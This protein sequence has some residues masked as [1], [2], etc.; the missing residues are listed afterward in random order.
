MSEYILEMNH[1]TKKFPGVVALDDVSLKVKKGEIHAL[2]GE[3]GA[4]KSTLIKVLSGVYPS[5]SYEGEIIVK[6]Q[7]QNFQNIKDSE[8]IG[9]A[10][11]YQ[12]LTLIKLLSI[13]E[14][15]FL[16]NEF[17]S[18]GVIDWDRTFVEAQKLLKEVKLDDDP[19]TKVIELGIGKQ[20]LVEIAKALSKNVELLIL[21]EPTSALNE[22]DSKNLL[23]IIK[24]LKSKGVTC[25]YISH[26][27]EEVME[28]A[29]TVT[30]LRDG[31]TIC[32]RDMHDD[33]E[34][35]TEDEMIAN[36]VGRKLT[37]RFPRK[38]HKPGDVVMEINNWTV[39]NP[40]IHEK[41]VIDHVNL[42]A[43][44]G[45]I[46][47][48][49][50]LIGAG[51]TEFAMSLIGAYG[52]NVSGEIKIEGKPVSI[53]NPRDAI[54][55]GIGYLSEDRKAKGLVLIMDIMK[56]TSL[57]SLEKI[58]NGGVIDNNEEIKRANQF[59]E[60]LSIKTPS[61]EQKVENLSGGN[62]QKVAIAKWLMT[63]PKILILDEPTRGIDVGAKYEIYN[64]MNDLVERG[65]CVIMISSELPEI[66]GM[67]DRIIVMNRGKITG[68]LSYKEA[69]QEKVMY[70]ATG[71]K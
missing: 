28:I 7:K 19:E 60:R 47:G 37:Q 21:D 39:Y 20:Q 57:A 53:K 4:G 1:I 67:S 18:N 62:Q 59:V 50:G 23:S 2:V 44:K 24:E 3:N 27:L 42:K 45:E 68:E 58:S 64:I 61:V 48:I 55:N 29:D 51:R 26:K 70:Y 54:L 12:E 69:T 56:N 9:I 36:M 33:K 6:G 31:K 38:E 66:L 34:K 25:I 22:T 52:Y 5:N 35:L 30:I 32:T 14:N 15:I 41:V 40:E 49:A 16:G 65:V 46:L 71:G 43:R 10:V 11:I 17:H 63:D 8:K 13:A